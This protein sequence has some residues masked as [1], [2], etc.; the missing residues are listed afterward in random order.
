MHIAVRQCVTLLKITCHPAGPML[1][2]TMLVWRRAL[3]A[4]S[5]SAVSAT[6]RRSEDMYRLRVCRPRHVW[7]AA[8]SMPA[9]LVYRALATW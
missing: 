9:V 3:I 2:R 5:I 1:P 8:I 7:Q 6:S 4:L